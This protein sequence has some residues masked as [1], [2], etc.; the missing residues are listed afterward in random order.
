MNRS[1]PAGVLVNVGEYIVERTLLAANPVTA[2]TWRAPR[3]PGGPSLVA[4]FGWGVP[5]GGYALSAR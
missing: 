5:D 3:R 1:A 2:I 4:F